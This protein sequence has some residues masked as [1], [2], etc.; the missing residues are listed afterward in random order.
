MEEKIGWCINLLSDEAQ[1][2]NEHNRNGAFFLSWSP[3]DRLNIAC[4]GDFKNFVFS[5]ADDNWCGVKQQLHLIPL[6]AFSVGLDNDF[7][8]EPYKAE[9]WETN[10]VEL[11]NDF[12][13]EPNKA[14][15]GETNGLI[16]K[17]I[18]V[19]SNKAIKTFGLYCLVTV[20]FSDSI[21]YHNANLNNSMKAY[22][23]KTKIIHALLEHLERF[24]KSNSL[25]FECI[26]FE[27][28]GSE[29]FALF[30]L[31][32]DILTFSQL[33]S[34]VRH[35]VVKF[36]NQIKKDVFKSIYTMTGFNCY[37]FDGDPKLKA[38]VKFN[39]NSGHDG[40]DVATEII[41]QLT[42]YLQSD[43]Y[44]LFQSKGTIEMVL[45]VNNLNLW[46][47]NKGLLN[48]TCQL[49]KDFIASSRT[50][51]IEDKIE[52]AT[53]SKNKKAFDASISEI[54][55]SDFS[56]DDYESAVSKL[57]N[58]RRK[59]TQNQFNNR[60]ARFVFSEY[61]RLLNLT[62]CTEWTK[63]LEAQRDAFKDCVSYFE[64]KDNKNIYQNQLNSLIEEMQTVLT[65]I[66]QA[67][68]PIS[69]IPYHNHYYSGS[70]SDILK[71]YY[72]LIS[73]LFSIGY[74]IPRVEGSVQ[75]PVTFGVKFETTDKIYTTMYSLPSHSSRIA[76]FHLPYS[77]LYDFKKSI[78]LLIH[79]VFHYV[80]P[81]DRALRNKCVLYVWAA[82]ICNEL[83]SLFYDLCDHD[84]ELSDFIDAFFTDNL[85]HICEESY[86]AICQA[87]SKTHQL[88]MRDFMDLNK[89]FLQFV[90]AHVECVV[91]KFINDKLSDEGLDN[92]HK[93]LYPNAI[94]IFETIFS[95]SNEE[96]SF[97][98]FQYVFARTYLGYHRMASHAKALK[99]AFCDLFMC[100]T[101]S[102]DFEDYLKVFTYVG[103]EISLHSSDTAAIYRIGIMGYMLKGE[104]PNL[105]EISWEELFSDKEIISFFQS[106]KN[107]LSRVSSQQLFI[108]NPL[109]SVLSNEKHFLED[110]DKVGSLNEIA[111]EQSEARKE[112]ADAFGELRR[113]VSNADNFEE[114]L[115]IIHNFTGKQLP[116]TNSDS[117]D[118]NTGRHNNSINLAENDIIYVDSLARY[119]EKVCSMVIEEGDSKEDWWYRGVCHGAFNLLP[120]LFRNLDEEL[121]LYANQVN[122]LK[123]AYSSTL[124]FPDLWRGTIA[125]HMCCLQHYG[126][127][128]NLLDFSLDMLVALHFALNPD[129]PADREAV[130]RGDYMP[131]VVIFKPNEYSRAIKAL[132]E[133]KIDSNK[134]Y[135]YISPLQYDMAKDKLTGFFPQDTDAEYLL[136]HTEIYNAGYVPSEETID[137]PVPVI[138]RRSNSRI[139]SQNGT[140]LAYHLDSR[141]HADKQGQERY[142]YLDLMHIQEKY[143]KL[144]IGLNK[145]ERKFIEVIHI[146]RSSVEAIRSDLHT[147]GISTAK[148]YPE[149]RNIFE[150]GRDRYRRRIGLA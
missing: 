43:P 61:N 49:Y 69:E 18:L 144:L 36:D 14:E 128:T 75:S 83:E 68:A 66:N 95:K 72:G 10:F 97:D 126:M 110:V 134:S 42:P 125:E 84:Q 15:D 20:R 39:I 89:K 32:D 40:S 58:I 70:F 145:Q 133:G 71:M 82:Y 147:L 34:V 63:I 48:G 132:K 44:I 103:G 109:I 96:K 25:Q 1:E 19:K 62:R 64:K 146:E 35:Q 98:N 121:S 127:P 38:L 85:E 51:W 93:H 80:A 57:S 86:K 16:Q 92:G 108:W 73:T 141:P 47:D 117:S 136:S 45:N 104:F 5:E 120:G 60:V 101:L 9:E 119:V 76:I 2:P 105:E 115:N 52:I 53:L 131:V 91:K 17:M 12:P 78:V 140:F 102:L 30:M 65:H 11:D 77:A 149:L 54:P 118:K 3:Y 46:H 22:E 28:L 27:S 55:I 137:Y 24:G 90:F 33:L 123:E 31:A 29:D 139:L 113:I 114:H 99:E 116:K 150:E 111:D 87:L 59:E 50:Y 8:I 26:S 41:T 130:T 79:E 23:N 142:L 88:E 74:R 135:K 81:I 37:G 6:E 129:I 56:F 112:I 122:I 148:M 107:G 13:N 100:K 124:Q 138:V 106:I 4:T 7:S 143:S 67:C 21:I 94:K